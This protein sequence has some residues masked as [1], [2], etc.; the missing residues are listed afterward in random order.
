MTTL[1]WSQPRSLGFMDYQ[2]EEVEG[3]Q[4]Y[5]VGARDGAAQPVWVQRAH[6]CC[7]KTLPRPRSVRPDGT[8]GA[9][10]SYSQP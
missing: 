8:G 1:L 3:A 10:S 6:L 4:C 9:C 2:R 5:D 7:L